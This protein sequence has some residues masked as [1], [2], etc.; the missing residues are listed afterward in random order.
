MGIAALFGCTAGMAGSPFLTDDPD[1]VDLKH[2]EFNLTE[3][4]TLSSLGRAGALTGEINVGCAAEMQCHIAV[5]VAF[6]QT[7]ERGT[8]TGLGDAEIGLKYRFLHQDGNGW[9]AAIYPTVVF[10]TGSA[11][12][13]LGNGRSQLLL[14]VWVQRTSGKWRWE[15]GLARTINRAPDARDSWFTGLLAQRSFGD[16]LSLGVEWFRRTASA[17]DVPASTGFN[18]GA[19]VSIST[20]QN[21]LASAGRGLSQVQL[22]R[23]SIFVAYQLEL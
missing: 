13:G 10:P 2:L 8:R 9:S 23:A 22:N 6:A 21:I 20:H 14:P 5:P 1:T 17:V 18:I 11:D 7:V 3:Q 12:R 15:T 4:H 19:I 16:G